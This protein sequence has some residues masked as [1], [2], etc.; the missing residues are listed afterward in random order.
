[1]NDQS[2]RE[3]WL[4]FRNKGRPH[5][6]QDNKTGS[7]IIWSLKIHSGPLQSFIRVRW[8][9]HGG[10]SHSYIDRNFV[11]SSHIINHPPHYFAALFVSLYNQT[12]TGKQLEAVTRLSPSPSKTDRALGFRGQWFES[13]S[14]QRVTTTTDQQCLHLSVRPVTIATA[15]RPLVHCVNI[16]KTLQ[17]APVSFSWSSVRS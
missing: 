11:V 3:P 15:A 4:A 6:A 17:D 12:G 8:P 14:G 7:R 1:M 13:R 16:N 10:A 5:R 2:R 9:Q